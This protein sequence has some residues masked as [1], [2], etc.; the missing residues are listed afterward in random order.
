MTAYNNLDLEILVSTMNRKSLDF[1]IPMFP[2][3]HFS[4]F[5]IL[6]INQTQAES[7]LVS[8][9]PSVRVINS[10][11]KG[12]S[13]S[14]NLALHNATKK[15][16]VIA[17]DDV[18][19]FPNFDDDIIKAFNTNPEASIITFNHQRIGVD[20]PQKKAKAV[21]LHSLKTLW[22]V[23]SIEIA[24]NT[25]VIKKSSSIFNE[26]FGLGAVFQTAEEFLFLRMAFKN[27]LK[28]YFSPKVIVSH[29]LLSSGTLEGGNDLIFGRTA[30]FYKIRG[31]LT[32]LWLFR[33]I[34]FLFKN[35]YIG[36]QEIIQKF[37]V[38]VSAINKF[39]EIRKRDTSILN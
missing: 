36:Q 8:D 20:G 30:L 21:Y 6:V 28:I 12:L 39:K 27:G 13:K 25:E 38:G 2:F 15:I 5:S 1:L 23:S 31:S 9:Y 22:N 16:A 7:L 14:R 32:Y 35:K 10:F 24:L 29:P 4:H 34:I 3:S 18:I 11:E 17:D 26:Y 19:Y 33:Y 37:K